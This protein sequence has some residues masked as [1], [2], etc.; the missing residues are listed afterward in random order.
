M[1]YGKLFCLIL[2]CW[3][4]SN[5][6]VHAQQKCGK[7]PLPKSIA[8]AQTSSA[9]HSSL[10]PPNYRP[11]IADPKRTIFPETFANKKRQKKLRKRRKKNGR[12]GCP[13]ARF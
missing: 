9:K 8:L 1:S 3:W 2:G 10:L 6:A 7:S 4:W 11:P 12:K 5:Q 13:S